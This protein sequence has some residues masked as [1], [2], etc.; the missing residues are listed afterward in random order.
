MAEARADQLVAHAGLTTVGSIGAAVALTI[1]QAVEKFVK[2]VYTGRKVRPDILVIA[3]GGSFDEPDNAG[4]G[5]KMMPGIQDSSG[6]LRSNGCQPSEPPVDR[7]MP[8]K[9]WIWVRFYK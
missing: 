6:L 8:S 3:H 7:W 5:L 1:E 2:I 9:G 4:K